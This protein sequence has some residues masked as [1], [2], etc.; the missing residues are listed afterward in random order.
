MEHAHRCIRGSDSGR[1][2]ARRGRVGLAFAA[3]HVANSGGRCL[4]QWV[5]PVDAGLPENAATS[6][7]GS[8]GRRR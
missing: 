5:N 4:G 6:T 3:T 7:P 8:S 1:G 2:C